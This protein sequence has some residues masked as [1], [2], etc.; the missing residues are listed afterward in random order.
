MADIL[1]FQHVKHEPPGLIGDVLAERGHRLEVRQSK[2]E[3]PPA[4]LPER[5][6]GMVV[7]GG[8]QAVYERERNPWLAAEL[9]LVTQAAGQGVPVLG[10]C[11]G[12]Q[13]VAEALGGRVF[14]GGA[15]REIGW[16]QI[17]LSEAGRADALC[18]PLLEGRPTAACTVFQWHGDTFSLPP[19]A[20]V[21]ASSPCYP[22][23]AFRAG[24]SAYGFQ[25]HFE[26]D[27]EMIADWVEKG[28]AYLRGGGFTPEPILAGRETL[29]APMQRR[30]RKLVEAF[31]AL[32]EAREREAIPPPRAQSTI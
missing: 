22:H 2:R 29:L 5:C 31:A 19:S 12:A 21:L 30:G 32:I 17:T 8:P 26:V 13:I 10:V 3:P 9:S 23:Q 14:P 15:G 18:A 25:F 11:L 27:A 20:V 6:G 28:D 24:P 16:D 7:M 4:R 1:V